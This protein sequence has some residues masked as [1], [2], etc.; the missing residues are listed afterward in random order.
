MKKNLN[1]LNKVFVI[2]KRHNRQHNTQYVYFSNGY[3]MA[4]CQTDFFIKKL[5]NKDTINIFQFNNGIANHE[6][7][8]DRVFLENAIQAKYQNDT[9]FATSLLKSVHQ[10]TNAKLYNNSKLDYNLI[11]NL[12]LI[13]HF[14][15]INNLGYDYTYISPLECKRLDKNLL[16]IIEYQ[17]NRLDKGQELVEDYNEYLK[18]I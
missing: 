7:L 4:W 14:V 17:V 5:D 6:Q 16:K 18:L 15:L 11:Y 9:W 3:R 13:N 8:N 12:D 10:S 1:F 2:K